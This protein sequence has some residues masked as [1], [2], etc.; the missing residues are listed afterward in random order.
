MFDDSNESLPFRPSN[1]RVESAF[2][3]YKFKFFLL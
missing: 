1:Y 2:I 3:V